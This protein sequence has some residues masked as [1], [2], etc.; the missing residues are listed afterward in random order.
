MSKKLVKEGTG[1]RDENDTR[2]AAERVEDE[3][4]RYEVVERVRTEA[5]PEKT[6]G[7]S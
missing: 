2:R 4:T 7:T 5:E 1:E 6:L 3:S